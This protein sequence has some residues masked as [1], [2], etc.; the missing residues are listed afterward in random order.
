MPQDRPRTD[1]G[2]VQTP[3]RICPATSLSGELCLAIVFPRS[4]LRL[5]GDRIRFR[6]SVDRAGGGIDDLSN[7]LGDTRFEQ[8][9][10]P[11]AVHTP[12]EGL[13]FRQRHL[14]HV[15]EDNL[16]ARARGSDGTSIANIGLNRLHS[17]ANIVRFVDVENADVV[18]TR[19]QF[20]DK[21]IAEITCSSCNER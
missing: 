9:T 17:R 3:A 21:Q 19:A 13:F 4:R 12:K 1:D 8:V 2:N 18:S 7:V 11:V 14:S 15:V 20:A 10:S 16:N 5:F 6:Y